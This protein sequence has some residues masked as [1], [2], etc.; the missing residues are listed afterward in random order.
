MC[1]WVLIHYVGTFTTIANFRFDIAEP[2][3]WIGWGI[4]I[5]FAGEFVDGAYWLV[6]WTAHFYELPITN[7]LIGW[8][9]VANIPSRQVMVMMAAYGH[10]RAILQVQPGFTPRRINALTW[11]TVAL[12]VVISLALLVSN[13][14]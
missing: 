8:G 13:P 10:I 11:I 2:R 4:F 1:V 6:A 7:G 12:G 14:S 5:G 9:V 3:H